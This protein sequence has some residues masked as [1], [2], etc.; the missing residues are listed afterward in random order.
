M[1]MR[2]IS[3][4]I[5]LSKGSHATLDEVGAEDG[6]EDGYDDLEQLFDG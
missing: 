2:L 1:T 6:S 4:M 3:R 5:V